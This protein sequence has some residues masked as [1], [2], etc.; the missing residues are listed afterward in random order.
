MIK[1]QFFIL[2]FF[3]AHRFI[4]FLQSLQ[5]FTETNELPHFH[6]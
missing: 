5:L 2:F 3:F 4:A 1:L 6:I